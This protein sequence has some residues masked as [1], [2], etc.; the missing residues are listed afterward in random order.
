LTISPSGSIIAKEVTQTMN[1]TI[2]SNVIDLSSLYNFSKEVGLPKRG[3]DKVDFG[4]Y[5]EKYNF[6]TKKVP[7]HSG[8]YIWYDS[9]SQKVI[10]IGQ[11]SISLQERLNDELEKDYHI[12]WMKPSDDDKLEPIEDHP[13]VVQMINLYGKTPKANIKRGAKKYRA[14]RIFWI[15]IEGLTDGELDV[16]EMKLIN[17]YEDEDIE[18][19]P[20]KANTDVRN[21]RKIDLELFEEVEKVV[22]K[23]FPKEVEGGK[24]A[25]Q[26]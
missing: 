11:T 12:F 19:K 14:D 13:I 17:K 2:N 5:R 6:L 26:E 21:Y 4:R 24:D 23:H 18:K 10:Y 16:V 9:K 7:E 20:P 15:S 1:Y 8:W 25:G 22:N 3:M